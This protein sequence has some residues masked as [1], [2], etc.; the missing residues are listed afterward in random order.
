MVSI[1][2]IRRPGSRPCLRSESHKRS[3]RCMPAGIWSGWTFA[4][5]GQRVAM[6]E[7]K[8]VGGS[9][10]NIARLPSKNI[11]HTAQVASYLR[12][13]EKFGIARGSFKLDMSAVRERKRKMVSSLIDFDLAAYKASGA[14]LIMGSGRF[15]GPRTV[16][17]TLNDGTQ[18]QIWGTNVVKGFLGKKKRGAQRAPLLG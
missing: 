1:S 18:R 2:S 12:S 8:Y 15:I 7:R 17:V 10:P 5:K 6:I 3:K 4:S 9:C 14:E 11:I 16:E 13:S